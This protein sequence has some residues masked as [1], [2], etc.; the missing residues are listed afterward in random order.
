MLPDITF[1]NKPQ[2][3]GGLEFLKFQTPEFFNEIQTLMDSSIENPGIGKY[4]LSKN[5]F[6]DELKAIIDKYT[7][8]KKVTISLSDYG[9]FSV[10]AGYM[11]PNNVLNVKDI[12]KWLAAG[13]STLGRWF[14]KN[15]NKI[16]KG[17]VDLNTGKVSGCYAELPLTI[18]INKNLDQFISIK[19]LDK[20]KVKISEAVAACILHELGHVFG[21]LAMLSQTVFDNVVMGTAIKAITGEKFSNDK[22]TIIKDANNILKLPKT[23]QAEIDLLLEKGDSS[24]YVIY[25]NKMIYIRNSNRALSVGVKEMNSEVLADMYAIRMGCGKQLTAALSS[26]YIGGPTFIPICL[27]AIVMFILFGA[28]GVI[29]WGALSACIYCVGFIFIKLLPGGYNTPYRRL[30]DIMAQMIAEL[31]ENK[32]LSKA[33]KEDI[34]RNIGDVIKICDSNKNFFEG[35]QTQRLLG[36]VFTLGKFKYA[37]FEHYTQ[38]ITNHRVNVLAEQFKRD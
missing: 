29:I 11:A 36:A 3:V 21:A 20:N 7:G 12:E 26:I 33:D 18:H 27:T 10:D 32:N 6:V 24:D 38:Q 31:K 13:D 37:D 5:D 17:S 35:T 15:S 16:F 19:E 23:E 4:H 2:E 1:L 22:A 34:L 14:S 30:T 28:S 9:N 25:F 8:F